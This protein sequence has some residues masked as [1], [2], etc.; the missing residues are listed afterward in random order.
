M[1]MSQFFMF[2]LNPYIRYMPLS[3][4]FTK[5]ACLMHHVKEHA[6]HEFNKAD[7]RNGIRKIV[8]QMLA[9]IK[10]VVILEIGKRAEMVG[11]FPAPFF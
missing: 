6:G 8:G 9:Y 11:L 10:E 2:A 1:D 4:R 5:K 7:I 3:N